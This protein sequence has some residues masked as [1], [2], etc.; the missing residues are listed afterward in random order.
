MAELSA[1][2]LKRRRNEASRAIGEVKK[3]GGDAA[4]QI[5][6]VGQLKSRIEEL[7]ARS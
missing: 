1:A 2:E 6:A 3:R 4:E 5:A 7:E